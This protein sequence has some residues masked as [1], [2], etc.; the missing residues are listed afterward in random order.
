MKYLK[1]VCI[2]TFTAMMI[3]CTCNG[4]NNKETTTQSI[5]KDSV[6]A[7]SETENLSES[8]LANDRTLT[9]PSNKLEQEELFGTTDKSGRWIAPKNSYTDP[10][11]GQIY[12]KEGVVIG[13]TNKK[14]RSHP[15]AAG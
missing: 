13:N 1:K 2:Y 9:M 6:K 12:N 3:C 8:D 4:C 7:E 14:P 11:T 5:Q 15:D 10:K